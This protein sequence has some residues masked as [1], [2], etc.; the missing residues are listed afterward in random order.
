[1]QNFTRIAFVVAM[2]T[3]HAAILAV[4]PDW[5][6][7][8]D[9]IPGITCHR[10]TQNSREFLLCKSGVGLVNA[11]LVTDT[12]ITH[13]HVDAVVL[14]GAGGALRS[15]LQIGDT[16]LAHSILQHDSVFIDENGHTLMRAGT[17]Y[18]SEPAEK[19]PSPIIPTSKILTQIIA[20]STPCKMG[21]ILSGSSFAGTRAEKERLAAVADDAL[22]VEMEAAG[23]ALTCERY[24]VAFAVAKTVS[25]RLDA[26]HGVSTDYKT[27]LSHAASTAASIAKMLMVSE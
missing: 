20:D 12:L 9:I 24:G 25:D 11:A 7:V 17:L 19:H 10:V 3:E 8:D 27:F 1:M 13:Y 6:K 23:V 22:L 2:D 4:Q 26:E 21:T 14:L 5:Q 15:D 16:V 18:L